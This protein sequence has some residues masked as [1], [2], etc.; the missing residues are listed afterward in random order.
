MTNFHLNGHIG[1]FVLQPR[2]RARV[3]TP[4][5]KAQAKH[6]SGSMGAPAIRSFIGA[7]REVD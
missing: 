1:V 4:R 6:S 3:Q 7:L 5:I 2:L